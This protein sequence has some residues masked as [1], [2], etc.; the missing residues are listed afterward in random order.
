M[1]AALFVLL[2]AGP[3]AADPAPRVI[4]EDAVRSHD[5]AWAQPSG[6]RPKDRSSGAL[7]ATGNWAAGS[8]IDPEPHLDARPWPHGMLLRPQDLGASLS[9]GVRPQDARDPIA[10][11]PGTL[12]QVPPSPAIPPRPA[13]LPARLALGLETGIC[14]LLDLIFPPAI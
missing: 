9:P 4:P 10:L 11:A 6:P 3:A 8:V 14:R 2:A 7:G 13:S 12:D 5:E 1:R